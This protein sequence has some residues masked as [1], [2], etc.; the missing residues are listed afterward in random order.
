MPFVICDVKVLLQPWQTVQ[1]KLTQGECTPMKYKKS[2]KLAK[3][4]FGD[5]RKKL[6]SNNEIE[7]NDVLIGGKVIIDPT[8]EELNE[9]V[10]F[11][12]DSVDAQSNALHAQKLV[13][14]V[15]AD[16][17]VSQSALI[18]FIYILTNCKLS[19]LCTVGV[20]NFNQFDD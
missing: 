8:S 5:K 10:D 16:R 12:I 11:A 15:Y 7:S 2:K 20:W 1:K 18:C 6:R 9:L 19:K 13:R 14:V 3:Q 17:Q 4:L